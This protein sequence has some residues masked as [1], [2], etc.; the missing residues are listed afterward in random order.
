[1]AHVE[2]S[3]E[4][5]AAHKVLVRKHERR[6]PSGGHRCCWEDN[7]MEVKYDTKV[8]NDSFE[9]EQGLR[10]GYCECGNE[11]SVSLKWDFLTTSY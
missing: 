2:S 10:V 8:G 1:M 7:E 5:R 6:I 11:A 4:K 9:M 3:G